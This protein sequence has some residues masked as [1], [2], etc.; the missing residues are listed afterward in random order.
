GP[1][2]GEGV[3]PAFAGLA[4]RYPIAARY[5]RL[6]Q[7]AQPVTLDVPSLDLSVEDHATNAA[8]VLWATDEAAG[9]V[10]EILA[11]E[12][13]L[14]YARILISPGPG[15]L[16][17]RTG[18]LIDRVSNELSSLPPGTL[19]DATHLRM[20]EILGS[21]DSTFDGCSTSGPG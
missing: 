1:P 14:A 9:I 20:M 5:T 2:S 10:T 4:L 11:V 13:L 8:E 17:A 19:P 7:L 3:P 21:V 18:V 12:V 16:G 15:E 6:R